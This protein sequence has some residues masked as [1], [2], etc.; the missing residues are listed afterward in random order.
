VDA[1]EHRWLVGFRLEWSWIGDVSNLAYSKHKGISDFCEEWG[2]FGFG[3][4]CRFVLNVRGVPRVMGWPNLDTYVCL[5]ACR[6]LK[7]GIGNKCVKGFVPPDKEP[8]VINKL[9]G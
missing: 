5:I 3:G 6:D 2:S 9:K 4:V 7:F 8:R 1:I